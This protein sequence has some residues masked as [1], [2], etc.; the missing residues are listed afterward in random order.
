[1]NAKVAYFFETTTH[2]LVKVAKKNDGHVVG[3]WPS[4]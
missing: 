4:M 2:T 3:A 1:V